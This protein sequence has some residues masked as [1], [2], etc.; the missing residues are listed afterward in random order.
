M[1]IVFTNRCTSAHFST[2]DTVFKNVL[3]CIWKF[4][5]ADTTSAYECA[6]G[7]NFVTLGILTF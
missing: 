3:I 5:A 4:C 1:D 2:L 7:F 6:S